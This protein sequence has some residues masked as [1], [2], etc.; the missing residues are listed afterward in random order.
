MDFYQ[1]LASN[2]TRTRKVRQAPGGEGEK[3]DA[4]A[5]NQRDLE[6]ILFTLVASLDCRGQR[7]SMATLE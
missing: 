3:G 5:L 7:N 1:K 4:G 6:Y 2:L